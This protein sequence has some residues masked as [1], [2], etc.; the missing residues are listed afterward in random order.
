MSG[1]ADV[2]NLGFMVLWM[3][4]AKNVAFWDF[5]GGL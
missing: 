2:S 3:F 1:F 4:R 5:G